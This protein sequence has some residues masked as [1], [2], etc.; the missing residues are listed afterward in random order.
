M[1][2]SVFVKAVTEIQD[3]LYAIWQKISMLNKLS[4]KTKFFMASCLNIKLKSLNFKNKQKILKR[5]VYIFAPYLISSIYPL[6]TT[7][8]DGWHRM[9]VQIIDK[10]NSIFLVPLETVLSMV[11]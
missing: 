2:G 10:L 7:T 3:T 6:T 1:F 11:A 5:N 4:G 8:H 9:F